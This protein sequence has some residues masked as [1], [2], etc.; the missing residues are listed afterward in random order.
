MVRI[1]CQEAMV[2]HVNHGQAMEPCRLTGNLGGGERAMP[3]AEEGPG[4]SN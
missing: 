4:C 2:N 1:S 3:M